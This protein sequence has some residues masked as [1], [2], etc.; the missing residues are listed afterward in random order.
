MEHPKDQFRITD[1]KSLLKEA[2]PPQPDPVY[3]QHKTLERAITGGSIN[4]IS[5]DSAA[6]SVMLSLEIATTIALT[7]APV[8]PTRG[9]NPFTGINESEE[10]DA[11]LAE[12]AQLMPVMYLNTITTESQLERELVLTLPEMP[13]WIWLDRD[14]DIAYP[15]ERMRFHQVTA[16]PGTIMKEEHKS[17]LFNYIKHNKV[18]VVV[19]NSF[20]FA[21]RTQREKDDL[22]CL[23]KEMRDRYNVAVLVFTHESEKRLKTNTR[24]PL[25]MLAML[26]TWIDTIATLAPEMQARKIEYAAPAADD[27]PSA[28]QYK[29]AEEV[30]EALKQTSSD[31]LVEIVSEYAE[32]RSDLPA[33]VGKLVQPNLDVL[34]NGA[35]MELVRKQL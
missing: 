18:K 30:N 26:S 8:V 27:K 7:K 1:I 11:M 24:G 33:D 16:Q 10:Y 15:Y 3:W 31:T 4:V 13:K 28:P 2:L 25:A 29:A 17:D 19:L 35:D 5:T 32:V 23:L 6:K 9:V 21:C 34:R 20:E 12:E 14:Q 22:A